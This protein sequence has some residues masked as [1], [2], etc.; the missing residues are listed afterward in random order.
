MLVQLALLTDFSS[1]MLSEAAVKVSGTAY[2]C[3]CSAV[4]SLQLVSKICQAHHRSARLCCSCNQN[5]VLQGVFGSAAGKCGTIKTELFSSGTM[6]AL[7][8][9]LQVCCVIL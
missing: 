9:A 2:L 8:A 3:K 6:D 4:R 1:H 5:P 7:A